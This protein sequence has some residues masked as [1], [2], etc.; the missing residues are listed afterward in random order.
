MICG[1]FFS[2]S[3]YLFCS[4]QSDFLYR[5]INLSFFDDLPQYVYN[6]N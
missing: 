6:Q 2:S 5:Y 3:S 1:V 4:G